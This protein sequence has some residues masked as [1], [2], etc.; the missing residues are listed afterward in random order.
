[1]TDYLTDTPRV[2]RDYCPSCEPNADPAREI[3]DVRWC[4]SHTPNRDGVD[5][6][7]VT[8]AAYLS[9]TAEAGGDDNRRLC[10]LIHRP[11]A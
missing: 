11:A 3:L 6:E 7:A 5:D 1:V 4:E 9:G 2:G 10:E 8:A